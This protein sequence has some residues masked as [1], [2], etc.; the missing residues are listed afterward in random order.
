MSTARPGCAISTAQ[1]CLTFHWCPSR[2]YDF[3]SRA[4]RQTSWRAVQSRVGDVTGF[5]QVCTSVHDREAAIA[6][7]ASAVKARLAAGAQI[8]GP[9][10][11][12]FWHKGEFG[13]GEE[14]QVILKTT[15]ERYREL[16]AHLV[17]AHPWSNPEVTAV[18]MT[19]GSAPYLAWIER[20]VGAGSLS[21]PTDEV[22]DRR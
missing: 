14:W 4:G 10:A 19:A 15:D 3:G 7:A 17:E 16:E 13:T 18:P 6:L 9:V 5:L 8:A 21:G 2:F 22:S 12:V 11:S 1:S 20:A